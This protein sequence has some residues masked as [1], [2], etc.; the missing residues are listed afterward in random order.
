LIIF[1]ELV[2][3]LDLV[4]E[5]T[6]KKGNKA[7]SDGDSKAAK[8]AFQL[9]L[10]IDKL[11]RA[12]NIGRQRAEILDEVITLINKGDNLLQEE[13]LQQAKTSYQQALDLDNYTSKAKQKIH[14]TDQKI[15]DR[16]FN[17]NMSS[18]FSALENNRF[19]LARQSFTAALK[20]KSRSVEAKDAL[21]QTKQK[22]TT[23]RVNSILEQAKILE[24][25]ERWHDAL[26]KYKSALKLNASLAA[27][28][29]GQERTSIRTKLD[30]R[31]KQI[32]THPERL[33][34]QEVYD[35]TIGFFKILR[36]VSKPGPALTKQLITLTEL[37]SIASTPITIRLQSDNMTQVT[38]YKVGEFGYFLSKEL[39]LRPGRYVAVGKRNGYQDVRVSIFVD[40]EN[41][42]QTF[43][44]IVMKKIALG[45][46]S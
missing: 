13:Q 18:G 43:T 23:I 15:L 4:F 12:A 24:T 38:L 40:P 30:D 34:E 20:L 45:T 44:I 21:K 7:L 31:L 28:Q 32:L 25:E 33:Y 39:S 22:I 2:E 9:A 11:D 3:R 10:A 29:A 8:E 36:T 6:M 17:D 26:A 14:L 42:G 37:L 19:Q 27:A 41:P 35:E 46:H 5:E 16:E 1:N